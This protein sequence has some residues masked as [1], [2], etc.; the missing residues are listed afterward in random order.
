M[1]LYLDMR[2]CK[3]D[4]INL[5]KPPK[6][7]IGGEGGG[8]SWEVMTWSNLFT[9]VLVLSAFSF[10]SIEVPPTLTI[11]ST[12]LLDI[13]LRFGNCPLFAVISFMASFTSPRALFWYAYPIILLQFYLPTDRFVEH[14]LRALEAVNPIRIPNIPINQVCDILINATV[15]GINEPHQQQQDDEPN[16]ETPDLEANIEVE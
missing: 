1:V 7:Q 14:A 8:V 3:V 2:L 11:F 10:V 15:G 13:L 9:F 6:F 5:V 16:S 12:R 4:F